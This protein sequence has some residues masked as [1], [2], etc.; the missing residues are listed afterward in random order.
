MTLALHYALRSDVGLLREGNED[1]AYAGPNLLAI[2]DGMGG[3]AAGEVA[4]AVAI[5]RDRPARPPEPARQRGDARRAGRRGRRGQ[6]HAARHDPGRPVHRG[7]GHDAHRAAVVR[8]AGRHVPHRRLARLP[9]AG[10]RL[11]PDHPR[12]HAGPVAGRRGQADARR[13]R[14]PTRSGPWSCARCRAAP[15]PIPTWP[16]ARP[17]SATGTCC[18]PTACPTWSPSRPCTR[19][20]SSYADPEQAVDQLIDLAIRSGGP[21][22]ITC[23]VADVVDTVT[24]PVAPSE[25]TVLAGAAANGDGRPRPLQRQPGHPRP[26]A[27]HDRRGA[28]ADRTAELEPVREPEAGVGHRAASPAVSGP[29]PGRS[30]TTTSIGAAR[31][32]PALADGQLDPGPADH[33]RRRGRLRRPGASPRASTTW[34][35]TAARSSSSAASTRAWPG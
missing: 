21:D 35:R 8:R 9:A 26:P 18:A 29:P 16:C 27:D 24:G 5:G 6:H 19:R 11:L 17:A 14:P 3:H 22:N 1:S 28:Q 13:P 7:H 2:A 10:R 4:S 31:R 23:I 20:W 30:R 34:A 12:P 33:P 25:A 15:T 32:P